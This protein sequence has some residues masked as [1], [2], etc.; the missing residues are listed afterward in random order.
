[1]PNAPRRS[2]DQPGDPQLAL[3]TTGPAVRRSDPQVART[4]VERAGR[5][6]GRTKLTILGVYGDGADWTPALAAAHLVHTRVIQPERLDSHRRRVQDLAADG[7]LTETPAHIAAT[8][9]PDIGGTWYR[10]T[11]KGRTALNGQRS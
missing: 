4:A 2:P 6:V 10:I 7:Y 9:D 8:F 11:D 3:G 1:M 5:G